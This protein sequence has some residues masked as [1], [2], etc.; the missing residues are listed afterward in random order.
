MACVNL[1]ELVGHEIAYI[2][3]QAHG[4]NTI[5]E[6]SC[7]AIVIIREIFEILEALYVFFTFSMKWFQP[8]KDQM[9][10]VE[11]CL[12]LRNLPKMQ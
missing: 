8:L 9:I 5:I 10:K 4:C 3:C 1:S 12:I 7:N 11:N 6:H 2:P